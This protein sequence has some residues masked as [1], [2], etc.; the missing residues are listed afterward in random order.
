MHT[1]ENLAAAKTVQA[2]AAKKREDRNR[3]RKT[4][5]KRVKHKQNWKTAEK[6]S[7]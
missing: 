1:E 2:K 6:K 4:D 3:E 7:K 5:T